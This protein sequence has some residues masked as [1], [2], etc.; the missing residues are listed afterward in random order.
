[1]TTYAN[2]AY[3][4]STYLGDVIAEAD[5]PRLALRAS[6]FIDRVTFNT[7]G[8]VVTAG[9]DL[10][11]IDLIK[12]ATCAV[13]EKIKSLN[14][15]GGVVQSERAGDWSVVYQHGSEKV[16]E[17]SVLKQAAAEY[18]WDTG[19]MYGGPSVD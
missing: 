8:P 19:L 1:M 18:L 17:R 2:F 3:Y 11:K 10:T 14:E 15:S 13:A 12:M 6:A 4:T 9:T 7:A 5:F 16:S